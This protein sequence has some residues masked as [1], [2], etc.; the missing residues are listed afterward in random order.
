MKS[1]TKDALI[2]IAFAVGYAIVALMIG[3]LLISTYFTIFFL[4]SPLVVGVLGIPF[5]YICKKDRGWQFC[6]AV[7][8]TLFILGTSI[9]LPAVWSIFTLG[10]IET[11]LYL[12]LFLAC[13]MLPALMD[14][15]I[16]AGKRFWKWLGERSAI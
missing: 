14:G 8:V 10:D 3:S 13:Y 12:F 16:F 6:V 2:G 5:Y 1:T 11:L 4:S 9:W 15:L 7:A